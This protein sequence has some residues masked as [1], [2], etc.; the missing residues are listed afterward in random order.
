[1]HNEAIFLATQGMLTSGATDPDSGNQ[2]YITKFNLFRGAVRPE[3]LVVYRDAA[4][5]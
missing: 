1:M 4:S 5:V 3:L 2:K